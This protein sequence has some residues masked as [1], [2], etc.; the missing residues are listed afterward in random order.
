MNRTREEHL[1]WAK[2]RALEYL[3]GNPVEAMTFD[4]VR[5]TQ[6]PGTREPCGT[7][8]YADVLRRP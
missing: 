2:N 3:P 8:D 1:E 7:G 6:A 5:S 4:G